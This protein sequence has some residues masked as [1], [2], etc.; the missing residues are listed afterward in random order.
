VLPLVLDLLYE[1]ANVTDIE[2]LANWLK[3]SNYI[4]LFSGA[5][6]STESGLPDF[7]SSGGLWTNN[8]RFEELASVDALRHDYPAFVEFYRWRIEQLSQYQPH[9]GHRVIADWQR[10]GRV[11]AL[12]TQ[13]VDGFHTMAGSPEVIELHGTLRDTRCNK[14]GQKGTAESFLTDAGLKCTACGGPM[15]PGVVLFGEALP[16]GAIA[17]ASEV[18]HLSELFLVLGSSLQVSPANWFPQLAKQVGA[19]LVIVNH[20]PTP[21]DDL[22]DMKLTGSIKEMLTAVAALL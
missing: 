10:K 14:C 3:N 1:E 12:I 17:K 18:S 7:R 5:G 19:K 11:Q 21:L 6:M 13:N 16:E 9:V 4:T 20:D 8:R 2:R 15:R 22:A